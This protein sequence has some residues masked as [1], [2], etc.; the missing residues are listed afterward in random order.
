MVNEEEVRSEIIE[1]TRSLIQQFGIHKVTMQDIAKA[2][3]RG[4]STLYYYFKSK[5]EILDIVVENEMKNFFL[6]CKKAV[7]EKKEFRDKIL[8]YIFTKIKLL[9]DKLKQYQ[10]LIQSE[11]HYLDFSNYFKKVRFLYDEKEIKLISSILETGVKSGRISG[12]KLRGRNKRLTAEMMLTTV[13]G[14]EMEVF[15]NGS[16]RNLKPKINL[17]LNLTIDGL[18]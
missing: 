5:E 6:S 16:I 1:T 10:V 18:K 9:E 14:L 12:D 7:E 11:S 3:G 2:S 8:A 13:R 15:V 17:M 4:K